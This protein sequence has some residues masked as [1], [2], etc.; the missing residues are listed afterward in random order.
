MVHRPVKITNTNTTDMFYTNTPPPLYHSPK[1]YSSLVSLITRILLTDRFIKSCF[2]G[3]GSG[4][5]SG[6][7]RYSTAAAA[8][9]TWSYTDL[10]PEKYRHK[11][12]V[13]ATA[14]TRGMTSSH[15]NQF[16][17]WSSFN[18]AM[19]PRRYRSHTP[20]SAI[21]HGHAKARPLIVF[22]ISCGGAVPGT[23]RSAEGSIM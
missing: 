15:E 21:C 1:G 5:G 17:K 18:L 4:W 14:V 20:R 3:C 8:L 10:N 2:R 22:L 9:S 6:G 19:R 12:E 13:K 7:N 16:A 11:N 23:G